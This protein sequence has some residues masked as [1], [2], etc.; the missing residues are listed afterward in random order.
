[1]LRVGLRAFEKHPDIKPQIKRSPFRH[2][3]GQKVL[4]KG[5]GKR[6]WKRSEFFEEFLAVHFGSTKPRQ[7]KVLAIQK[8]GSTW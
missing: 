1:M 2:S 5:F 6:F 3:F 8:I 7:Y 4:A